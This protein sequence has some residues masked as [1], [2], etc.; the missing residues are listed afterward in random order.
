[1]VDKG[2][3]VIII[4]HNLD[5]IKNAD[6]VIDLGPEAGDKGGEIVCSG[7]PE[8]IAQCQNSWTGVYLKKILKN[9]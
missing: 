2:N 4:E 1:L 9:A 6:F 7:T 5:V 8:D 3:S